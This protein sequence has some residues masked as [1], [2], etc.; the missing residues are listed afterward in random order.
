MCKAIWKAE[1]KNIATLSNIDDGI[2]II[3]MPLGSKVVSCGF[4]TG[5]VIWFE[6][7]VGEKS[8]VRKTIFCVHTGVDFK[9]TPSY[10]F[11]GTVMSPSHIVYHLYEADGC[12]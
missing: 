5:P 6:V 11:I 4:Q 8:T 9:A 1:I 3:S 10:K 7:P 12:R 2:N